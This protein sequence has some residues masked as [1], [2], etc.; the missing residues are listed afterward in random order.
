MKDNQPIN[1]TP[2]PRHTKI[3][4]SGNQAP[5]QRLLWRPYTQQP[6]VATTAGATEGESGKWGM[7]VTSSG[8][9]PP[10]GAEEEV[11]LW[12]V[13]KEKPDPRLDNWG[14]KKEKKK[15][16]AQPLASRL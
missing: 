12:G 16:K 1:F 13:E 5:T 3:E 15:K 2:T 4:T 10:P 6:S 9:D 14:R 11:G 7:T 8:S